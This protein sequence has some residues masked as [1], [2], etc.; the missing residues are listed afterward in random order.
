MRRA[1]VSVISNF[2]G[3]YLKSSSKEKVRY[4]EISQGSLMELEAQCEICL[5]LDYWDRQDYEI[6]DLKRAEIAFLL[7]R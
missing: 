1:A 4:M 5:I 2:V 6:F 7:Y 3:G